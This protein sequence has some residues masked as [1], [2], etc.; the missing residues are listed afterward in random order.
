MGV[1]QSLLTGN[2]ISLGPTSNATFIQHI[3]STVKDLQRTNIL[4]SSLEN[5]EPISHSEWPS[6]ITAAKQPPIVSPSITINSPGLPPYEKTMDLLQRYFQYTG[7]M[8]PYL[9]R[10]RILSYLGDDHHSRLENLQSVQRCLVG[11]CLAFSC[12]HGAPDG[13]RKEDMQ[14][15]RR[16]FEAARSALPEIMSKKPDIETSKFSFHA[17][18][19]K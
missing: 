15:A 14:R 12:I 10:T 8:F 6:P 18:A 13:S 9:H 19:D 1:L 2:D 11:T 4:Q 5:A 17:H 16:Y 3:V 7:D